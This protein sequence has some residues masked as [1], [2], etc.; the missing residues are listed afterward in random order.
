M[1]A[2]HHMGMPLVSTLLPKTRIPLEHSR[3]MDLYWQSYFE[4]L[5]QLVLLSKPL[6]WVAFD[7]GF[8]SNNGTLNTMSTAQTSVNLG[9]NA[10]NI[11]LVFTKDRRVVAMHSD[12][13]F[14]GNDIAEH[15]WPQRMSSLTHAELVKLTVPCLDNTKYS[16]MVINCN[17]KIKISLAE[18]YLE[19]F[20]DT[21]ILFDLKPIDSKGVS[22]K[23]REKIYADLVQSVNALIHS[24]GRTNPGSASHAVRF[25][26]T[27]DRVSIIPNSALK[28]LA[29][30]VMPGMQYYINSPTSHAC[31]RIAS[32]IVSNKQFVNKGIA[33]CYVFRSQ[34][35]DDAW[36]T[37][38]EDHSL[39]AVLEMARVAVKPLRIIC[40]VPG[41]RGGL[42]SFRQNFQQGKLASCAL[43][44]F[45]W[46]HFP[47]PISSYMDA[48][49]PPTELFKKAS[50]TIQTYLR[51]KMK[52]D[53]NVKAKAFST[54]STLWAVGSSYDWSH[55]SDSAFVGAVRML[56]TSDTPAL[57]RF[58]CITKILV[59]MLALRLQELN[60]LRL[61][62]TVSQ[63]HQFTW[64]QIFSSQ[65]QTEEAPHFNY[66][67]NSRRYSVLSAAVLQ[68]TGMEFSMAIAHYVLDPMGLI[69]TIDARI[70]NTRDSHN[71]LFGEGR[72]FVGSI[73]DMFLIGATLVNQGISPK[74]RK[75]VISSA[76]VQ[77]L[78][79]DSVMHTG[80]KYTF[81]KDP[82]VAR[83]ERF[84]TSNLTFPL[85]TK[86]P[87]D[88]YGMGIWRVAGWRLRPER[89]GWLSMGGSEALL[90]FDST[91]L[92]VAMLA[93]ESHLGLEM[94]DV[95]AHT[96]RDLGAQLSKA[97]ATRK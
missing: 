69:G 26:E 79:G 66:N 30:K 37:F 36:K 65:Y 68:V 80:A 60:L 33:G 90:Y 71:V 93:P 6:N 50:N 22:V 16:T 3:C 29:T 13:S 91:G 28:L 59:V 32:W 44:G 15:T 72:G 24:A 53:Q 45:E 47:F 74:T 81:D 31:L 46:V 43:N 94:T 10:L 42:A 1:W 49:G 39:P 83:M 40:D 56:P 82:V 25:F 19:A 34:G 58:R 77:Q 95:F 89:E 78:L 87:V 18:E 86:N 92:I 14:V 76:S 11:D 9:A 64:Y 7:G 35:L 8:H 84:R 5:H 12:T 67:E 4:M 38:L 61:G 51:E 54:Y 55:R 97:L 27:N 62:D 85:R 88:G 63:G 17:S 2:S 70:S 75:Q 48:L 57:G 52:A 96:V 41:G 21:D 23:Q 73:N 20:P